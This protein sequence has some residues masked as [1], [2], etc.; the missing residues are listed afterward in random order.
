MT[1]VIK[2]KE[3]HFSAYKRF[4]QTRIGQDPAWLVNLR[5][6]AGEVFESRDFPTTRE[7]EW[8]Y[9]NVAPI[10]KIPYGEGPGLDGRGQTLDQG[11]VAHDT[12]LCPRCP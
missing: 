4:A 2:E 12:E 9:T 10:L 1:Q 8:K 7:E 11:R 6:K 5:E 3:N